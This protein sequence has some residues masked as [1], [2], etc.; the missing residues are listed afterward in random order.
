MKKI[1]A[2]LT[3]CTFFLTGC[4]SQEIITEVSEI[5]K[6]TQTDVSELETVSVLAQESVPE[7]ISEQITEEIP[8]FFGINDPELCDYLEQKINAEL[9]IASQNGY[10]QVQEVEARYYSKERL[11][12]LEY[13]SKENIYFGTPL[14]KLEKQF[15]GQKYIFTLADN[16]QT[17]FKVFEEYDNHTEEILKTA[18]I[19]TGVIILTVVVIYVA[20]PAVI[21]AVNSAG[22]AN[23]ASVSGTTAKTAGKVALKAFFTIPSASDVPNIVD[24]VK[25]ITGLLQDKYASNLKDDVTLEN[26]DSIIK[27]AD[28]LEKILNPDEED[29]NQ[30]PDKLE[31]IS[32]CAESVGQLAGADEKI[33][34]N[35]GEIVESSEEILKMIKKVSSDGDFD[36]WDAASVAVSIAKMKNSASEI[37]Q[38]VLQHQENEDS[39]VQVQSLQNSEPMT[40][41]F[42]E[43]SET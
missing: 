35:A 1:L 10:Y 27:Y 2:L 3:I 11:E 15:Q 17:M 19:V 9:T 32:A 5:A 42:G 37:R 20:A 41:I 18:A 43:T 24:N 4:V 25:D 26:V 16:G 39:A 23:V 28:M 22:V 34:K 8:E 40:V 33:T 36:V 21:A 7:N 6:T 12:E 29:I 14:S 30:M 13:N 31:I 38:S